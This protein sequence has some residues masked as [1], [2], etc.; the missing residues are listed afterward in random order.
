MLKKEGSAE[1][2]ASPSS[3]KIYWYK[4][5]ILEQSTI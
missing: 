3:K 4:K 2:T 1:F 5:Q